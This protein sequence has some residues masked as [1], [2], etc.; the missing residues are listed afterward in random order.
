M[1]TFSQFSRRIFFKIDTIIGVALILISFSCAGNKSLLKKRLYN[2]NIFVEVSTLWSSADSTSTYLYFSDSAAKEVAKLEVV[3][4]QDQ[5]IYYTQ[6]EALKTIE[7]S[8]YLFWPSEYE[9][10]VCIGLL[11]E[12]KIESFSGEI[13]DKEI[14]RIDQKTIEFNNKKFTNINGLDVDHVN[15]VLSQFLYRISKDKYKI[16]MS[17]P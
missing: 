17:G 5:I 2:E 13:N 9:G 7:D 8:I 6:T 10:E 15:W 3:I 4:V 16:D 12:G 1:Y 14:N 11:K